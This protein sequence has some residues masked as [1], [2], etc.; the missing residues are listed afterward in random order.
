M[1]PNPLR[2]DSHMTVHTFNETRRMSTEIL[3]GK[4]YRRKRRKENRTK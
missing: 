2:T 4:E 3:T 1:K